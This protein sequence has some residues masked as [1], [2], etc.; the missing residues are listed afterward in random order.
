MTMATNP[1]FDRPIIWDKHLKKHRRLFWD[2][3]T[4]EQKDAE[5]EYSLQQNRALQR[6]MASRPVTRGNKS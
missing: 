5:L 3:L 2:E 6:R 4:E 1:F